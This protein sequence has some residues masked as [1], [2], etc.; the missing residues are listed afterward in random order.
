M[1]LLKEIKIGD[2][3][4]SNA[5]PFIPVKVVGIEGENIEIE[6][7]PGCVETRPLSV[8]KVRWSHRK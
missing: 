2:N 1:K 7:F 3:L 4:I 8:I 6:F 5:S